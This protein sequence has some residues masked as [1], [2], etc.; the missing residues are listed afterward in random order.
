M[1]RSISISDAEWDVMRVL[2][3]APGPITAG[4]VVDALRQNPRTTKTYLNRLL[5][6]GAVAFEARGKVY[7]YSPNVT[8]DE[9]VRTETRSFL[10]RV[11]GGDPAAL[12][13]HFVRDAKLSPADLEHLRKLLKQKE[14]DG[15]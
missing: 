8:R 4:D 10:A 9:C 15:R 13:V 12:L 5:K 3:D 14:K 6:K 1:P 2:W 11:F 7:W